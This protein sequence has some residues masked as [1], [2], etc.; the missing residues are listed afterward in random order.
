M[1]IVCKGLRSPSAEPGM[2]PKLHGPRNPARGNACQ[3]AR[4]P[5][6]TGVEGLWSLFLASVGADLLLL[7]LDDLDSDH[8]SGI[9]WLCGSEQVLSLF[10]ASVS[11]SVLRTLN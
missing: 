2:F 10:V 3:S 11:P 4:S 5:A 6:S 1:Q 8:G 7:T 9:L